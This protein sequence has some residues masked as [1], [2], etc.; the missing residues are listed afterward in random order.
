MSLTTYARFELIRTFRNRR[1][2][3]FSFG[4][5]LALYFA[6]AG[7]NRHEL[8]LGGSGISAPVYF[9]TSLAA[10][11]AMNSVLAIGARIA[12]E[13]S[14]G[15][16]RQLRLTP[17]STRTYF[18]VKVMTAYATALGTIAAL[19]IAGA[20]LGVRLGAGH[21]IEMTGLLLVGLVP[22]A[23]IGIVLGLLL[24]SDSIGPAMGGTTALLGLLG[25]VWFP[26][27]AHGAMHAIAEGLPS[28]WL[29]QAAHVGI[30]GSAWG[31][32]G[33]A[34]VAAWAVAAALIAGRAYRRDNERP[35]A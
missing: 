1:F 4:F 30:G 10:F 8:D 12:A 16:N 17:L 11:G 31:P 5:P 33:W 14:A 24:T 20:F 23:A 7:P 29:V 19:Y 28:Y 25:G 21:W 6:V 13:R 9:M 15:W 2:V 32:T 34:V 18:R 22:F 26:I 27:A 35:S 3:I